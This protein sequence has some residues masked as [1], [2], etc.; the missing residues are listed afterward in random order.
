VA[1]VMIVVLIAGANSYSSVVAS[2]S[3]QFH[4]VTFNE[5]DSLADGV[6]AGQTADTSTDLTLFSNL[7]PSFSN[8]GMTFVS[9]NTA[10][11]GS[12]ITYTDGESYGFGA[13]L[14][15]YAI[16]VGPYV[17]VTFNENDSSSDS[18]IA[19]QTQNASS[20][21]TLFSN[22]TPS[23]KNVGYA[24]VDWNTEEGGGG[25][26][27]SNGAAYNFESPLALYAQWTALPAVIATF[28]DNEGVGTIAPISEP[29]GSTITLPSS[30]SLTRT[31][32]ALSGWNTAINGSGTEYAPGASVVLNASGTYYAQGTETSPLEIL[33]LD[34]GGTGS[35]PTL[36][37][38]AGTTVTLPGVT[39]L[40]NTGYTLTSWNTAANGSG[41]SYTLGQDLTLTSPLSLYAQ[42]TATPSSIKVNFNA[43]GG[44]GSL[45]ALSGE[46][47]SSVT[48]PSAASVVRSGYTLTSWNTTSNGS[49]TAYSLGQSLNL[50]ST[51]TLYAQWE[52]V[53]ASVLYGDVGVFSARSV[54]LTASLKRQVRT[55]ATTIKTRKYTKVA[56]FGF[57]AATGRTSLDKTL[58][59]ERANNVANYLRDELR[60]I[61]MTGVTISV[62]GQGSVE[63][64]TSST[65]SRVEV[66]V[67]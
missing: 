5:N 41:T 20:S 47:G 44:S 27:Y 51:L 55:L 18:T 38:E 19:A 30:E 21:L 63:G 3:G 13:P 33:I 67:S 50:T 39:G 62:S 31:D 26:S 58:S 46:A 56:L 49:G 35:E 40:T 34:N 45:V 7:N 53:P 6:Y 12:G 16:W 60:A 42:W 54:A 9:W 25:T 59:S 24:F 57:T 2:A 11:D 17:T 36:S 64:K 32:F 4:T 65:Y 8:P 28:S 37:G 61:E 14:T 1:A 22:L 66:F 52:K 15:L 29:F 23:F 10:P 43:N 48:L